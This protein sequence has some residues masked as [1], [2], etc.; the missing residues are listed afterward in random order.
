MSHHDSGTE[1]PA[2]RSAREYV[3]SQASQ[4]DAKRKTDRP[5]AYDSPFDLFAKH[6]HEYSANPLPEGLEVGAPRKCF[7]NALAA[8]ES[9]P[10]R[11]RYLE[12]EAGPAWSSEFW[13]RRH[14]W[15][16]DDEDRAFDVTWP[17]ISQTHSASESSYFGVIVP[18]EVVKAILPSRGGRGV[19]EGDELLRHPFVETASSSFR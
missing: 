15:I 9:N 2:F 5:L 16:I 18:L 19:F 12:G 6:G 4:S 3:V 17:W 8:V 13:W 10:T 7:T 11:F 14:A 1:L